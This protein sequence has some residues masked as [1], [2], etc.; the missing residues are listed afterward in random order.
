MAI[1]AEAFAARVINNLSAV[2]GHPAGYLMSGN[3]ANAIQMVSPNPPTRV[4]NAPT[5]LGGRV[6]T[7]RIPR[8]HPVGCTHSQAI[9]RVE[10]PRGSV[11]SH[12][13]DVTNVFT[14]TRV[15]S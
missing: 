2:R 6:S 5:G 10:C 13:S 8:H 12:L 14:R 7:Y 11:S 4:L 9:P 1:D 15:A 3:L